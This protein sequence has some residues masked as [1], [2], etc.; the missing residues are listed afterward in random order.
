MKIQQIQR[1]SETAYKSNDLLNFV[2]HFGLYHL[3]KAKAKHNDI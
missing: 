2:F 3:K 1:F